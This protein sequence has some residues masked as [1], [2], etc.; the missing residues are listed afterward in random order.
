MLLKIMTLVGHQI[1]LPP[2]IVI[3]TVYGYVT[4]KNFCSAS[5]LFINMV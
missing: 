2:D 4:K 3:N 1:Y 5:C